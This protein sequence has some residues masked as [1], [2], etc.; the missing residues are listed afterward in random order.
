MIMILRGHNDISILLIIYS[1]YPLITIQYT[2]YLHL[3]HFVTNL[4]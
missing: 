1:M 2:I 3:K 4:L